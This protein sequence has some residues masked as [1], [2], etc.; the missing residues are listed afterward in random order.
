M[1]P[2]ILAGALLLVGWGWA[3]YFKEVNATNLILS[4]IATWFVAGA[5]L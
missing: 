3:I 2:G 4:A 1:S 5:F